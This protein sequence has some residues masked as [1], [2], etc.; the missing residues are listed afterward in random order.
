M[1]KIKLSKVPKLTRIEWET[2]RHLLYHS[3][4]Y[5]CCGMSEIQIKKL[6][7]KI[8][9]GPNLDDQHKEGGTHYMCK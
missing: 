8:A 2:I 5:D 1:K 6:C 9:S 3:G 7:K 4:R